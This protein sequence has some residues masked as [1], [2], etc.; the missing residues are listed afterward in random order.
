[1][2]VVLFRSD[3]FSLEN[4]VVDGKVADLPLGLDLARDLRARISRHAPH[5]DTHDPIWEDWGCVL[6][7][8]DA[9]VQYDLEVH[10]VGF[11]GIDNQWGIRFSR[12]RGCLYALIG[13]RNRPED[14][15]P[16]QSVVARVL[17]EAPDVYT[18][19]E[20]LSRAEYEKRL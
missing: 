16:I 15:R 20:W 3:A 11:N 18:E 9:R 2:D 1:M 14:C 17:E 10:W 4:T 6:W 19:V 5:L 13:R 7:V 12:P 8:K